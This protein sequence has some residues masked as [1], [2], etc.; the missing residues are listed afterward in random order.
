MKWT[1][2]LFSF[3]GRISRKPY[4]IF[5]LIILFGWMVLGLF[6]EVSPEIDQISRPQL[7]FMLWILWPSLAVQAKRWH[8][9]NKSAW[10]ILINFIP[11]IGP[12]WAL[13]ENGFLPG[14][15]GPNRFGPPFR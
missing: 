8:D 11:L 4:W 1:W 5:N 15:P 6:T 9:R 12:L 10:W 14:T 3:Q 2:L 7:M 13:I